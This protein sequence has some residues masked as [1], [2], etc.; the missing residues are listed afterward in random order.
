MAKIIEADEPFV[1]KMC[2]RDEALEHFA[3]QGEQFKV[4]IIEDLE[5]IGV[6]EV[7][8]YANGDFVD[9]CRGPH[10]ER[11]GAD[12]RLQAAVDRRR[13]LARRRDEPAAPAHLRH[14]VPTRRTST[15]T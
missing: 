12:R 3:T 13:V 4:E 5:K 14:R 1:K 8:S 11:T 15:S 7:S 6:T 2:R 10:V 9:L